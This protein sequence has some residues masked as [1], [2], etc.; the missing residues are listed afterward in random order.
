MP[1]TVV[2]PERSRCPV[3][4]AA[5]DEPLQGSAG[6]WGPDIELPQD[7]FSSAAGCYLLRRAL[8][9]PHLVSLGSSDNSVPLSR[10]ASRT[11]V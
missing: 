2:L 7:P 8:L 11:P 9:P 6:P 10:A 1:L 4:S 3:V 5:V